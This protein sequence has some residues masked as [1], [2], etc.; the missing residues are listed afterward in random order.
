MERWLRIR[1]QATTWV[2]LITDIYS[3]EPFKKIKCVAQV[4][5]LL[6]FGEMVYNF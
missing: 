5:A 1:N 2:S 3:K 6:V 4:P